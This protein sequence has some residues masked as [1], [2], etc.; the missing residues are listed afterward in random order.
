MI[1]F[2]PNHLSIYKLAFRHSSM[3]SH[4]LKNNERLEFLGDAVLDSIVA[5]YLFLKFPKRSE[6]FLTEMKSKIVNRKQLGYIASQMAIQ[7]FLQY[8]TDYVVLNNNI[9]GNA[10]EALIGAVYMDHGYNVTKTFVMQ[11]IINKYI[12][13][14]ILQN[15]DINF[16]SKILEWSQKL[17]RKVSFNLLSE[18]DTRGNRKIFEIEITLDGQRVATGKGKNKKTAEKMAAKKA[19]EELEIEWE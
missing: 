12:D 4:T 1:G 15:T 16:K 3:S 13:L 9:L 10:L 2:V 7:D 6:G 19:I 17:N 11:K 18:K 14:E 8:D 5:H